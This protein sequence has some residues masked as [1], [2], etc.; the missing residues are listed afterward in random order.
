MKKSIVI[1]FCK[2]ET[3]EYFPSGN[4]NMFNNT[5]NYN[6]TKNDN[7][8]ENFTR[9]QSPANIIKS[10]PNMQTFGKINMPQ[11]YDECKIGCDRINPDILDAFRSNP[12][13]F[14][15]TNTA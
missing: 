7:D 2:K 11:Y 13:T 3:M 4:T 12:Y 6:I 14:S 1:F 5:V 8:I 9:L 15:L 10:G